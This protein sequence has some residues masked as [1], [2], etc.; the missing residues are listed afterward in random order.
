MSTFEGMTLT[1]LSVDQILTLPSVSL[2]KLV[3]L[4]SADSNAFS[5]YISIGN[6]ILVACLAIALFSGITAWWASK[7][8]HQKTKISSITIA[9]LAGIAAIAAGVFDVINFNKLNKSNYLI[10][11]ATNLLELPSTPA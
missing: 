10:T 9:S 5:H 4:S 6:W 1:N 7:E 11:L 2:Q 8:N 3:A